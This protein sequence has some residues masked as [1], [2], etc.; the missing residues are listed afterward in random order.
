MVNITDELFSS[1]YAVRIRTLYQHK[2]VIRYITHAWYK[3]KR[4]YTEVSHSLTR[5]RGGGMCITQFALQPAVLCS[6]KTSSN[7]THT[8]DKEFYTQ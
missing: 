5:K 7:N 4:I 6:D 8:Q 1:R 2:A 3:I